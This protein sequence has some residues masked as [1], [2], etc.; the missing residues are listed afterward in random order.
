M[1]DELKLDSYDQPNILFLRGCFLEDCNSIEDLFDE[2]LVSESMP[3]NKLYDI[4]DISY[5]KIPTYFTLIDKWTKKT[6]L[7][8]W[9]CDCNF[10]NMPIFIPT[11][12]EN[13]DNL[14]SVCGR[15]DVL[16]NFCTWNCASAYI[17]FNYKGHTKWEKHEM[18]K[19][20]YKIVTGKKIDEILPS[21]R[22]TIM[23]QYGGNKTSQEYRNML[24]KLNERYSVSIKHIGI[25]NLINKN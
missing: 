6:N 11:V 14:D 12:I 22:K 21:P 13:S 4:K 18:L 10:H 15:M 23:K 9:L 16:G 3:E 7:K 1:G 17:N 24:T 20:L 25:N 8:C 5:D 19:L 2:R